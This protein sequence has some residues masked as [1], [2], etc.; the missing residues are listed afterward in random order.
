MENFLAALQ[1]WGAFSWA[2]CG[3]RGGGRGE[4]CTGLVGAD[5]RL[6][7]GELGGTGRAEDVGSVGDLMGM[8]LVYKERRGGLSGLRG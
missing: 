4:S 1:R 6:G 7:G 8:I 3:G 5:R 2:E